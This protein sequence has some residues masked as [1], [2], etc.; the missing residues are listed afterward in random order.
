MKQLLVLLLCIFGLTGIAQVDSGQKKVDAFIKRFNLKMDT[1]SWLC[2]YDNIAWWTSD[3]VYATSKEEQAKLGAEWFCFKIGD[4]WHAVYGKYANQNYDMVYH[5]EVDTTW[6]V[7]RVYTK[8]DS[9]LL[10]AYSR[11]LVN[12]GKMIIEY[13]DTIKVRFNQFIRRNQDKSLSIWFLPAFTTNGIAVY[14]GEFH[15]V[16]DEGGNN[17][18]YK[19]EYSQQ[20]KGFKPDS[21]KEIWL[22]YENKDEPTLGSIFFVW[23]YRKYFDRIVADARKFRS[24]LFHDEE[25]SYYWVHAVKD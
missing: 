1:V 25:K 9:S 5:Y 11:A 19:S 6:L 21:K 10:N 4:I 7:K 13:P 14:G 8:V 12:A 16:F 15:Y 24:T 23:Y 17:L 3:S 22:N 2:E 18:L 20:Y